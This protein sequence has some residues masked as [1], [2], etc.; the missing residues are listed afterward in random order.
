[1]SW[2]VGDVLVYK[3]YNHDFEEQGAGLLRI[4][5]RFRPTLAGAFV[6]GEIL[7]F[8]DGYYEWWHQQNVKAGR[9]FMYHL[10]SCPAA[11]CTSG[12]KDETCEVVHIDCR[13]TFDDLSY[14][15][16]SWYSESSP[17]DE[18]FLPYESEALDRPRVRPG[19]SSFG[20]YEEGGS[21][22]S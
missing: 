13:T 10:C 3:C 2:A 1:M 15:N 22:G 12:W 17:P 7:G 8:S 4:S 18:A 6:G 9:K 16:V 19:L 14:Q 21:Q 20:K 5:E 11:E